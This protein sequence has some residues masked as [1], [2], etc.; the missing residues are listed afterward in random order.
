MLTYLQMCAEGQYD[1]CLAAML[2]GFN[3]GLLW[4]AKF[5]QVV[6][7]YF[8]AKMW[9]INHRRCDLPAIFLVFT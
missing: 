9:I 5:N 1:L 3:P 8:S 2:V 7:G 4:P 6:D